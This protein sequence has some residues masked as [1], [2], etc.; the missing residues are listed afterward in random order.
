MK[1]LFLALSGLLVGAAIAFPAHANG[2]ITLQSLING[3]NITAGDKLFDNWSIVNY[4][5]SDPSRVFNAANIEV[6]ALNDG[7]LSPGPGLQFTVTGGELTVT[8]DNIYAFVD[9]MF[10]FHVKVLDPAL[11]IKDNSLLYSPGGAFWSVMV[12]R[13]YD[14][15]SYIRENVDTTAIMVNPEDLGDLGTTQ[16]EFSTLDVGEGSS[17]VSKISDS[18]E[19]APQSEI[20][21]TKNVSVW[22]VDGTDSAG[23]SSFEQ[24]FSQTTVPEPATLL[25][26]ALALAGLAFSRRKMR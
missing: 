8:G 21:V 26:T 5:A 9:L 23:I 20:W 13:S 25:L 11:K 12:D 2:V 22:A 17:P 14:V 18:A 3:G 4:A 16:I 7:G 19:F 10:G 6:S 15:G 24:R 1:K